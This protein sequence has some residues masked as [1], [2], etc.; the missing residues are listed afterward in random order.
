LYFKASPSLTAPSSP[1]LLYGKL[2]GVK[3]K[4]NQNKYK[5]TYKSSVKVLLY[6]KASARLTAP[7]APILLYVKLRGVNTIKEK[8]RT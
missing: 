6:F 1:I 3:F 8:D 7:K 5:N 4:V 2:R